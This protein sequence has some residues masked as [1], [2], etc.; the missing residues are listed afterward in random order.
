[1]FIRTGTFLWTQ[2][3]QRKMRFY[4]LSESRLKRIVRHP[5]RIEEGI[6]PHTVACMQ[7]AGSSKNMQEIWVMYQKKSASKNQHSKLS[8]E[9]VTMISAWRYPGVSPKRNP[10]PQDILDEVLEMLE[11]SE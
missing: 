10:I 8:G 9:A 5:A 3:I 7:P 11:L 4:G 2:H 6:A 1:M